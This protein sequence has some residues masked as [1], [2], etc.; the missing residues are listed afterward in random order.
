MDLHISIDPA[1]RHGSVIARAH[2]LIRGTAED[3][4]ALIWNIGKD[5]ASVCSGMA[6]VRSA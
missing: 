5:G 4:Q 6:A 1:S 3:G 2:E